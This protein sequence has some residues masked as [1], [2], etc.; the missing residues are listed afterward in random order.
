MTPVYNS[1]DTLSQKWWFMNFFLFR[2]IFEEEESWCTLHLLSKFEEATQCGNFWILLSK[3]EQFF[4]SNQNLHKFGNQIHAKI[5]ILLY[6]NWS[7]FKF[8]SLRLVKLII[9]QQFVA[10]I[11]KSILVFSKLC[12]NN[13]ISQTNLLQHSNWTPI[14]FWKQYLLANLT[15]CIN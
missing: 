13:A 5:E 14:T 2:C 12:A 1:V 8:Y 3:S 15:K 10:L 11:Q 9:I 4:F 6:H 7:K